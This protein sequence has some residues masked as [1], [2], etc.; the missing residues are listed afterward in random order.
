[1]TTSSTT[2]T[3]VSHEIDAESGL[4]HS[5]EIQ[6]TSHGG[7]GDDDGSD[8][9]LAAL[10]RELDQDRDADHLGALEVG[11]GD[12]ASLSEAESTDAHDAEADA[13]LE[14][15]AHVTG[16]NGGDGDDG[17]DSFGAVA[18]E[19]REI[20]EGA[21]SETEAARELEEAARGITEHVSALTAAG[22]AAVDTFGHDDAHHGAADHHKHDHVQH[23]VETTEHTVE[24]IQH[25]VHAHDSARSDHKAR[26]ESHLAKI[27]SLDEHAKQGLDKDKEL[28]HNAHNHPGAHHIVEETIEETTTTT[29]SSHEHPHDDLHLG[30]FAHEALPSHAP[31]GLADDLHLD[32]YARGDDV[33]HHHEEVV[34]EHH[35]VEHY[36]HHPHGGDD[37]T[38]HIDEVAEV[39]REEAAARASAAAANRAR[40]SADAELRE[41]HRRER[42]EAEQAGPD[43]DVAREVAR[44]HGHGHGHGP[45]HSHISTT[46]EHTTTTV[47]HGPS[48]SVD[49]V[50]PHVD[51]DQEDADLGG[52]DEVGCAHKDDAPCLSKST[53][54]GRAALAER[55]AA[56]ERNKLAEMRRERRHELEHDIPVP[57]L[58]AKH[59]AAARAAA[60]AE[61]AR[62]AAER[63]ARSE[64]EVESAR[65][66]VKMEAQKEANAHR[67]STNL[68][69]S[70]VRKTDAELR[71]VASELAH[72]TSDEKGL[73]EKLHASA[74]KRLENAKQDAHDMKLYKEGIA[75]KADAHNDAHHSGGGDVLVQSREC[76]ECTG[77]GGLRSWCRRHCMRSQ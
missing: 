8:A 69:L 28:A 43:S 57:K 36:D 64:H 10:E 44:E 39:E 65:D 7:G 55:A 31:H 48:V 18:D 27:S 47:E 75:A 26:A 41:L 46:V 24:T 35:T 23:D 25:D 77:A 17:D 20:E 15:E 72:S 59:H 1:M 49:D 2:L 3:H 70:H 71:E 37:E 56:R 52:G 34:E 73:A 45:L 13:A 12:V 60:A 51:R 16:A 11:H 9:A 21:E 61:K 58:S 42:V 67:K 22:A 74:Q 68:A 14:E 29:S 63:L 40:E 76:A 66:S 62:L 33:V 6:I 4:I 50:H 19:A 32:A 54:E 5:H 38:A 30:A 53:A